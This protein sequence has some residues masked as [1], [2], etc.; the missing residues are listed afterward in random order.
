MGKHVL[1]VLKGRPQSMRGRVDKGR[2]WRVVDV[3][4]SPDPWWHFLLGSLGLLG[5][6]SRVL[7][8]LLNLTVTGVLVWHRQGPDP[9]DSTCGK[10]E[11]D[12]VSNQ[13]KY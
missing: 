8:V 11:T 10:R 2:Q 9:G 1:E 4:L 12:S 5:R 3:L 13:G 7:R 6:W